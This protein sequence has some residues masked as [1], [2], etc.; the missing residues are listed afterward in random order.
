VVLPTYNRLAL[1]QGAVASVLA[2]DFRD[3]EL[4]VV[5]DGSEDGTQA[6]LASLD[7]PRVIVLAREHCGIP[8][9]VR[10]EG[11]RLARGDYIAFLDS[12]DLW[13]MNKLR[14]Q[15]DALEADPDARWSY[16]NSVL[17]DAAGVELDR[18]RFKRWV[19]VSGSITESL[20]IHDAMVSLPTVMV[21]RRLLE[22]VGEF[23]ESLRY[24]EDFDLWLR[25]ADEARVIAVPTPLS[26][27]RIHVES[28]TWGCAEVTATFARV[29]ERYG[30]RHRSK[31]V[32][33]LSRR[34]QQYYSLYYAYQQLALRRVRPAIRS[35]ARALRL[36]PTR[37]RFW[38]DLVRL[39]LTA[40]KKGFGARPAR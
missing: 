31:K 40:I 16:T 18:A 4:I 14:C 5:D 37:P 13:L 39:S 25:L 2:Q 6:W 27:I 20:I 9:R 7:D 34:Q 35:L 32:R 10:N 29:Y 17:I 8:A 38:G 12:D 26:C 24:C 36:G 21:E 15:L 33:R 22:G 11:L 3:W 28:N 23:D 1:L 19:P 30:S